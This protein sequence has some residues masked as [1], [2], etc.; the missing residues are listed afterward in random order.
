M[1]FQKSEGVFRM[2]C[3]KCGKQ[4]PDG[5]GFCQFCGANQLNGANPEPSTKT[6]VMVG[7]NTT[8]YKVF[9][10]IFTFTIVFLSFFELVNLDMDWARE[11][12]CTIYE[13][14]SVLW[15]Y[16]DIEMINS[17]WG[18]VI[19]LLA[20]FGALLIIAPLVYAIRELTSGGF[21]N[22]MS[23]INFGVAVMDSIIIV[24][25]LFVSCAFLMSLALDAADS[26]IEGIS[27]TWVAYLILS[28]VIVNSV[29]FL[30]KYLDLC[31]E[32]NAMKKEIKNHFDET[33]ASASVKNMP[34]PED[35]IYNF[36]PKQIRREDPS[37]FDQKQTPMANQ[38]Q[39]KKC[40]KIHQSYVGS[41]GCGNTQRENNY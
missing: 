4:I 32:N 27:F 18:I 2:Y 17:A 15:K 35:D 13:A 41:C 24:F 23:A 9:S 22:K 6:Y 8:I 31:Y 40:G 39:C 12:S 28:F 21:N 1:L 7:E 26:A 19:L 25:I 30:T 36:R 33:K 20:C 38:W 14:C 5:S 34:T 29:V 3:M 10:I 16:I 11:K 37:R